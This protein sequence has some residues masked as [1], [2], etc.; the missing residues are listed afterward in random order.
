MNQLKLRSCSGHIAEK[1]HPSSLLPPQ[2]SSCTR[3]HRCTRICAYTHSRRAFSF[4][5][6]GLPTVELFCL[7]A[8]LSFSPPLSPP[9]TLEA[10]LCQRAEEASELVEES[11]QQHGTESC[12]QRSSHAWLLVSAQVKQHEDFPHCPISSDFELPFIPRQ[13]HTPGLCTLCELDFLFS[14]HQS[15]D[16]QTPI[17]LCVSNKKPVLPKGIQRWQLAAPT[18][19]IQGSCKELPLK[20]CLK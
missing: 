14:L 10:G 17:Y 16:P 19:V 2:G 18:I 11:P 9:P 4:S 5:S 20:S 3:A 15:R 8:A 1:N 6:H 13:A 12:P 7:S